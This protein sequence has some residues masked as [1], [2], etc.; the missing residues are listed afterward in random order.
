[1]VTM[2]HRLFEANSCMLWSLSKGIGH[3]SP[4]FRVLQLDSLDSPWGYRGRVGQRVCDPPR[5]PLPLFGQTPVLWNSA[6]LACLMICRL[7][8]VQAQAVTWSLMCLSGMRA[9]YT[10]QTNPEESAPR[11]LSHLSPAYLCNRGTWPTHCCWLAQGTQT[12]IPAS[13]PGHTSCSA[14]NSEAGGSKG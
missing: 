14:G 9:V 3:C 11:S 4:G 6:S 10:K 1:M 5:P 12:W 7:S 13:Q 8:H 2:A